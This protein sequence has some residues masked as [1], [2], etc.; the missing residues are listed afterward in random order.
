MEA[1]DFLP[2]YLFTFTREV[3]NRLTLGGHLPT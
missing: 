1:V 2:E 3:N